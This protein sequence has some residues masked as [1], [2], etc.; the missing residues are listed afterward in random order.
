MG[1]ANLL[2]GTEDNALETIVQTSLNPSSNVVFL[3]NDTL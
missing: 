1:F 3:E 2:F